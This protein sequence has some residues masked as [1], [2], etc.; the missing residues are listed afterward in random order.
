[1]PSRLDGLKQWT[2]IVAD[3]GDLAAIERL[4]PRD[5]TTNPSLILKAAQKPEYRPL[6][7]ETLRAH[8][9]EPLASQLDRVLVAFGARI[10]GLID[11]RVSTEV[12]ARL[13]FDA[14]A[15]IEK[16]R[17]L[18]ALYEALG[19]SRGRVLIK[20]A[21]TWEGIRAAEVLE[22]EGIHCN[23][24]LL[25]A[26]PQAEACAQAGVTLISPFVGRIYDWHRKA[27]GSQ[28]DEAAMSGASDPGVR[29]VRAIFARL[30]G[31]GYRTEVMGASFR[32]VGQVLALAGCDLL[33]ISPELLD[34]LS[35]STGE[36]PRALD[37]ARAERAPPIDLTE[38][39]FRWS[40][41]EDA[42]ATEK[43]AE[44]IRAFA[45]DAG[46]LESIIAGLDTSC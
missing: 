12:D 44:G 20:I 23:L 16:A 5:A 3:T 45:A 34:E 11:G 21:S 37:A 30:K 24:T 6:L 36:V 2:T 4:R 25:F 22:R 19:V 28:W 13:S 31:G 46:K 15:T 40:L 29:S 17:H 33:T 39:A 9:A 43:L 1:M 42:M 41:N 18:I 14:R 32:S 10:L 35:S 26:M 27:A 7:V 38:R 8:R